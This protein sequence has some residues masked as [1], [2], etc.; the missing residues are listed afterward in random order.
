[1]EQVIEFAVNH[2]LMVGGFVAV[3]VLLL[4]SEVTRKLQGLKQLTPAQAVAW[5]NDPKA[6]V[7]DISPAAEFQ[8]G[9][10]VNARHVQPSHLSNP[11]KETLKL[12]DHK[13]LVVCKNGQTAFPAARQL[14]KM[15]AADVAVLKGGMAAWRSDQFPVTSKK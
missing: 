5:I 15:G 12:K 6:V 14:L 8:K 9:H 1:M 13:L 2:P 10:I 4:W 11:D 7:V 3:L